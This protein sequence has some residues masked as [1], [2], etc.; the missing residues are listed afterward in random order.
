ML[1]A[2][3]GSR[4]TGATHKLSARLGS[5]TVLG[6]AVASA[7]ASE[8]GPV[9]VVWGAHDPA[10][11]L[12][13]DVH[14]IRNERWADGLATSLQ[15][16]IDRSSRLG[17]DAVIVG[18]GDQPG[19]PPEAWHRVAIHRSGP[20]VSAGFGGV[21]RPPVRLDRVVWPLLP[22]EGDEGARSLFA[23][24][25]ELVITIECDGDPG[26]IDTVEDLARWT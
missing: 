10:N 22:T 24:H 2:G 17:H 13:D 8:V 23:S 11:E 12:P 19:V 1:A 21:R 20:I 3:A 7:V 9:T 25:P 5:T 14:L 15:L 18:L 26:D 16:A 6:A 4:F